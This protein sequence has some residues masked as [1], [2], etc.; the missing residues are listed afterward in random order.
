MQN[1]EVIEAFRNENYFLA[2][3]IIDKKYANSEAHY[4]IKWKDYSNQFNSWE[5]FSNLKY[6]RNLIDEFETGERE[7]Y[8]RNHPEERNFANDFDFLEKTKKYSKP[9]AVLF[10]GNKAEK[11]A[12]V[13]LINKDKHGLLN[14]KCAVE[15]TCKSNENLRTYSEMSGL[16]VKKKFPDL[17]CD[18]FQANIRFPANE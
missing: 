8:M 5:P 3:R 14:L 13:E 4:L 18:Y 7:K 1:D 15:F 9:S 10:D 12:S 16:I 17:L 2:E 11:I 6:A